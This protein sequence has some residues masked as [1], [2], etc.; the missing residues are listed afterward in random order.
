MIDCYLKMDGIEGESK[1]KGAEGQI[2]VQSWQW[3]VQN[4]SS[5]T[6]GGG[7]GVG[8]ATPN[9]LIFVHEYDK[10]STVLA[11]CCASGKHI[12]NAKLTVCKAGE[13][14]KEFL[15]VAMKQVMVTSVSHG[16]ATG[17]GMSET[18]SLTFHDIE[19]E[20]KPQDDTGAVGASSK[21]GWNVKST[22]IR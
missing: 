11:K 4:A 17:G 12:A 2:E 18:V 9:E 13:G 20:Y 3:G 6:V 22:E 21:F 10:S 15:T 1:H 14:Q 7:S 16:G 8:K 19:F 5:S